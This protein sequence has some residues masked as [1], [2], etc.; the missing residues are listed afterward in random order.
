MTNPGIARQKQQRVKR[1]EREVK[2]GRKFKGN[3]NGEYMNG[4]AARRTK[5]G[6]VDSLRRVGETPTDC[7]GR[8][9]GAPTRKLGT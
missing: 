8:V 4:S 5:G 9:L 6:A 2:S 3:S 7:T 1:K